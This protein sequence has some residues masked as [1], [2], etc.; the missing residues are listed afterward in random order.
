MP[1]QQV[2]RFAVGTAG[3]PRSRTWRLWVPRG[4]SDVYVSSRRIANSV[5]VSLHEPGP[6]RFALTSEFVRE[7]EFVAPEGYD[8]RLAKEWNR[9]R[10][11]PGRVVRPFAIVVPWDEVVDREDRD[12]DG[13]L[14]TRLRPVGDAGH[15]PPGR[16]EHGHPAG[17]R[18]DARQRRAGVRGHPRGRDERSLARLD[19]PT[20]GRSRHDLDG[21]LIET[22]AMGF[23]TE[24]NPDA[25]DGTEVA[26]VTDVTAL[27][28]RP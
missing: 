16:A 17:R 18:G 25:D 27:G 23:G 28:E 22:G 2:L 9:P 21:N 12:T 7:Q 3:G 11:S 8:R 14:W 15:G 1:K 26:T 13:V 5:K 19:R 10:T 4:K 20:P 6:S 24:P